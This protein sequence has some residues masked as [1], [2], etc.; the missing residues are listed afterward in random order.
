MRQRTVPCRI[1][2]GYWLC[3]YRF[4]RQRT[5]PCRSPLSHYD[6]FFFAISPPMRPVSFALRLFHPYNLT[7]SRSPIS[8]ATSYFNC[9]LDFANAFHLPFGYYVE[10]AAGLY[11]YPILLSTSIALFNWRSSSMGTSDIG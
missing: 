3:G 8:S 5:V 7:L 1:W 6:F 4:L 11:L 9:S 10:M 2:L